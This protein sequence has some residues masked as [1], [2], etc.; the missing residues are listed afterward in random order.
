MYFLVFGQEV[1]EGARVFPG[2]PY[3]GGGTQITPDELVVHPVGIFRADR[4]EDACQAA[5]KRSRRMG[6]FFAVEGTPWGVDLIEVENVEQLGEVKPDDEKE[7]R[8][9]ALERGVLDRDV[10]E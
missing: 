2:A 4:A 5:A 10:P 3:P 1:S 9:R 6:T 7:R 8:I